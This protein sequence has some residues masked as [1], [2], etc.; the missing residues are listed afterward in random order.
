MNHLEENLDRL[1]ASQ[2]TKVLKAR[3]TF[4]GSCEYVNVA[5]DLTRVSGVEEFVLF[6]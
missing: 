5:S 4:R 3:K 2:T 1:H 6:T